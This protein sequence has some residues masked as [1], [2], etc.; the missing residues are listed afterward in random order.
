MA[1]KRSAVRS[2]LAPP[3][4]H[5]M[6][7]IITPF[8]KLKNPTGKHKDWYKEAFVKIMLET[9]NPNDAHFSNRSFIS[10]YR[11]QYRDMELKARL[12]CIAQLFHDC[13]ECDYQ[14]RL[15]IFKQL[16]GPVWPEEKGMF[17]HG[18]FLYP[19]SQYVE[20]YG[21]EDIDASLDFI[22]ALTQRFTGEWAIRPLA[23]HNK[24]KVLSRMR[25]WSRHQNFHVR[26][27][28]SEG[29]RA[30]LPWGQKI[31]WIDDDPSLSFPILKRLRSDPIL[32]VRRSVA[33]TIGD[34][35]RINPDC[36][37]SLIAEWLSEV[38]SPEEL[39]VLKHAIRTPVKKGL[40]AFLEI[41]EQISAKIKSSS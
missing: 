23:N 18:F 27:L 13:F 37:R 8:S 2:R 28:A 15:D 39:W 10:S 31:T 35:C 32:Y 14:T 17:T 6:S 7:D 5:I 38:L 41:K 9:L 25:K 3:F 20:R 16:L 12:N 4:Q 33:N 36:A 19:I 30:R 1:F 26:R 11:K 34:I 21:I 40:P 29:L 24:K 22:E